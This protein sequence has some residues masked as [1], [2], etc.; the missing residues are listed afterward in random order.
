MLA[1]IGVT[2]YTWLE[3][4]RDIQVS[5]DA[6]TRIA[7]AL[8]LT[9]SESLYIFD[10]A[11]IPYPRAPPIAKTSDAEI[12]QTQFVL[13]EFRDVPAFVLSSVANVEGYNALAD[14][15][16]C[17]DSVSGPFARNQ[18]WRFFMDPVR[19]SLYKD[20]DTLV[21]LVAGQ[22]RLMYGKMAGELYMEKMIADMLDGS[23]SFRHAWT[24]QLAINTSSAEVS[25]RAP[26]VGLLNLVTVRFRPMSAPE[27]MMCVLTPQDEETRKLLQ[28]LKSRPPKQPS[29][30]AIPQP[31]P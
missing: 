12:Q 20:W 27:W 1:G 28:R 26:A 4:G 18:I 15:I 5:S 7:H 16:F 25:L 3:Q 19:R 23:E 10:L 13:D 31:S 21:Q 2:W 6:L 8:R 14:A 30:S 22:L 11:E 29:H 9:S 24:R 17:F